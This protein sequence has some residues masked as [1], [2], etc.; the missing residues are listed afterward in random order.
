MTDKQICA[1]GN[2]GKDSCAGDSGGP[3]KYITTNL[4]GITSYVQ[5]GIVSYGPRHCGIDGQPGIYTKI[6]PYVKWILD[7]LKPDL[8]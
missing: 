2:D 8:D 6:M 7:N 1:G 4:W 3:L 5:Y